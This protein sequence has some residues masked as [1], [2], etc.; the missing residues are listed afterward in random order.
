MQTDLERFVELYKTFGIECKIIEP[1]GI[2]SSLNQKVKIIR[3]S[4][5]SYLVDDATTSKKFDGYSGFYSE[6]IFTENGE[7][8]KQGF[9]E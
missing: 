1:E 9:W 8:I 3:L 4:E 7:F 2:D 6:I 5:S